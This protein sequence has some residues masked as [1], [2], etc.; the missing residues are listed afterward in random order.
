MDIEVYRKWTL[1][2]IISHIKKRV[3]FERIF[4]DAPGVLYYA[5]FRSMMSS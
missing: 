5:R 1:F 3:N 2:E 4:N